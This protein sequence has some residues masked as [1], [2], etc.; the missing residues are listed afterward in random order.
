[1]ISRNKVRLCRHKF[2]ENLLLIIVN[3]LNQFMNVMNVNQNILNQMIIQDVIPFQNKELKIV[4][5]MKIKVHVKNVFKV[6]GE[7]QM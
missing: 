2:V 5:L 4:K 3:H 1:M 7:N 6:I